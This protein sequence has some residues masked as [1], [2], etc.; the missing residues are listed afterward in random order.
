MKIAVPTVDGALSLHFGHCDAFS[1]FEVDQDSKAVL[2]SEALVPPA[3]APGVLPAWLAENG[4]TLVIASGMGMRAQQIFA[5]SGIDV[6][7]GAPPAA[8]QEVVQAFLDGSL[9]IGDNV[10]EH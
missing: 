1:V 9:E 3:H 7:T 5:Q 6:V 4:V 8:P 2:N 10:C